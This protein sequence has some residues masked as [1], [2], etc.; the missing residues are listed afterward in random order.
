MNHLTLALVAVPVI[1]AIV[2][3]GY[4]IGMVIA[5][6]GHENEPRSGDH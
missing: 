1:L 5:A 4:A 2:L 6:H 3:G